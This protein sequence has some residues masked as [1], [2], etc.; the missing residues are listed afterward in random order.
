[1]R[2]ENLQGRLIHYISPRF[3]I[4]MVGQTI[5]QYQLLQK[6]G[7]GGMG[8]VYK[9]QDTRLNRIVAIKVLPAAVSS[10]ADRRRRFLQEAQAA[11]GL[12]HP[13]IITIYDIASDAHAQSLWIQYV[14][15]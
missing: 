9:A 6:L 10:D 2:K 11:S 4:L 15:R 12:N 1:M 13:N 8:E 14:P 7:A 5:L 3:S